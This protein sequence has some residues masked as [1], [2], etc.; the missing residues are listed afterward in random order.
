MHPGTPEAESLSE[1]YAA[2]ISQSVNNMTVT[3]LVVS[4]GKSIQHTVGPLIA[5]IIPG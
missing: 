3:H 4:Y 1:H 2:Q 5:C